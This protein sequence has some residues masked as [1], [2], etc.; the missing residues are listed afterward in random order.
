MDVDDSHR[1][2]QHAQDAFDALVQEHHAEEEEAED[3]V[4]DRIVFL[5]VS[6][7]TDNPPA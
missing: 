7:L 5:D 3:L 1:D 2:L 4:R 6:L